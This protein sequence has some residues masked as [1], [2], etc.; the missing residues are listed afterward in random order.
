MSLARVR[1]DIINRALTIIGAKASEEEASR[2][3]VELAANALNDMIKVWQS[4]GAHLWK[5]NTATLFVQPGQDLYILGKDSTDHATE[6]F[7]LTSLAS[8]IVS[9]A[10]V[11]TIN[12]P[13][14]IPQNIAKTLSVGDYIGIVKP[15]GGIYWD[16]VKT[17]KPQILLTSKSG[18][19]EDIPSGST[20]YYY[21]DKISKPLRIPDARRQQGRPPN[22]SEIEMIQMGRTD[23]LNL[24][25]KGTPGTPVQFYYDPKSSTGRLSL[26]PVPTKIEQ[27]ISFTYYDPI[28]IFSESDSDADFPD[29]WI[30]ALKYNLAMNICS[31]IMGGAEPSARIVQMAER[32][33]QDALDWDQGDASVFFQ[34]GKNR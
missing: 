5:R 29:E 17:V 32:Y 7:T 28:D 18:V 6:N 27:W 19:P 4:S 2:A 21:T 20:V 31:D 3:D 34:Y 1:N 14:N 10:T 15:S 25:N 22:F 26:W 30:M 12:S 13:S 8:D 16:T 23:Y 24:P 9:G 11:I 33:Y